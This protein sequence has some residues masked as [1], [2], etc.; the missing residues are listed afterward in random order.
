[1][2]LS[3]HD[4]LAAMRA[5]ATAARKLSF[6]EAAKALD[7]GASA[8]SRR[9]SSLEAAL[10]CRLLNRTTRKVTLTEAGEI[11]LDRCL[12]VLARLEEAEAAVS[13]HALEPRGLLRVALPNLYGQKAIAPLLPAFMAR[14][15]HVRLQ[16]LFEDRFVDLVEQRIDV[17][18]RIGS[19]ETGDYVARKLAANR[20][21]LCAAPAYLDRS[22]APRSIED[23]AAH[24]CLHF[25]PL[26]D[27]SAWR[28][29]RDGRDVEVPIEPTL[30]ADNAE[31]LRLA[32]LA[33]L[34][35]ALLAD[36]VVGE[37]IEAGRL[38]RVLPDW[39]VAESSVYVVYPHARHLPTKTRAFVDHLV[40]SVTGRAEP[41]PA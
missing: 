9:I 20:R 18:V 29:I 22:G 16:L 34:G 14:H 19:L 39:S 35:I 31:A 37:D 38:V 33:G 10:G 30:Q 4:R 27:G 6:V 3:E 17:G 24:D 7:I 1:M 41:W 21:S 11:Y 23:L 32:A 13:S 12:D 5:F 26:S 25:S 28:L 15:P 2:A 36:F 8:L 40:E